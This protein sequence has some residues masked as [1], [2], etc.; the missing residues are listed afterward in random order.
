M[1]LPSVFIV[2]AGFL[3]PY[4]PNPILAILLISLA[5]GCLAFARAGITAN[6]IDIAPRYI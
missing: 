2:T 4:N 5:V 3:N 1:L 6:L